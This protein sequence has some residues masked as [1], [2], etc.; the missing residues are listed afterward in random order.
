MTVSK[1]LF[2]AALRRHVLRL[3]NPQLVKTLFALVNCA[4]DQDRTVSRDNHHRQEQ[5]RKKSSPVTFDGA[6]SL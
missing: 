2:S 4:P 6:A 5:E 1:R 3:L